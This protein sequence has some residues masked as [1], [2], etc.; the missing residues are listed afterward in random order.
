MRRVC[1]ARHHHILHHH[2]NSLATPG[3]LLSLLFPL[4]CR[5][6]RVSHLWAT[7]GVGRWRGGIVCTMATVP[8]DWAPPPRRSGLAGVPDWLIGPGANAAE[9]AVVL[10]PAA[11]A[12]ITI[13]AAGLRSCG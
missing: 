9:T 7:I 10:F 13:A 5:F 11:A 1:T 6:R 2:P 3:V 4:L 8:T 12:A